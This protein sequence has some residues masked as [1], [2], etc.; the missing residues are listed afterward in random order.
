VT[1][2]RVGPPK[3][4]PPYEERQALRR[5]LHWYRA[6]QLLIATGLAVLFAYAIWLK[7]AGS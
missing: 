6:L 2:R 1:R 3:F 7:I 4:W 5:R